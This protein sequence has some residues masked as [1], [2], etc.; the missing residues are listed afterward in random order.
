[1]VAGRQC[2]D[3]GVANLREHRQLN[4][5]VAGMVTLM[6]TAAPPGV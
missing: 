5:P 6:G 4:P 1:L 3:W 2:A